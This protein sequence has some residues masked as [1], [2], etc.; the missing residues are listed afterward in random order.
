MFKIRL[1]KDSGYHFSL[2]LPLA[3]KEA[4]CHVMK[5]SLEIPSPKVNQQPVRTQGR[6]PWDLP[7]VHF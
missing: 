3:L 4:R 2:L 6:P 7:H 5:S 1:Q